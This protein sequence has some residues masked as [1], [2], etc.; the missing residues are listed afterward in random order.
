MRATLVSVAA[1]DVIA[2][3]AL[4]DHLALATYTVCRVWSRQPFDVAMQKTWLFVWVNAA[5]LCLRPSPTRMVILDVAY[6]MSCSSASP[7]GR[8]RAG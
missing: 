3:G 2:F 8:R 5:T 1:G 4:Y 7:D 6:A